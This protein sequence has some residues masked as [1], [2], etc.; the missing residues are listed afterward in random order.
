MQAIEGLQDERGLAG[1]SV[2][3]QPD[4]E[5][6]LP[7][8]TGS[9]GQF[10]VM[11]KGNLQH[12]GRVHQGLTVIHLAP[13]EPALHLRAGSEGLEAILLNFPQRIPVADAPRKIAADH[14]TWHCTLCDFVY[15]EAEGLPG[16][17]IAPGTRWADV[18]ADWTCPD[19]SARKDGFEKLEF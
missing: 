18:P 17:G 6:T 1:W 19:C 14:A 16:E 11:L 2:V 4:A 9:D 3:M 7:A 8:P 5:T 10:I 12:E 13:E 15:D